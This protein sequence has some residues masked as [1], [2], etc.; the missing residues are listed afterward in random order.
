MPISTTFNGCGIAKVDVGVKFQ[1][2]GLS[3]NMSA[4]FVILQ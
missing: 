2:W 4:H 3:H 1:G